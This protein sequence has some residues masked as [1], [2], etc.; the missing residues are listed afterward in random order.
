MGQNGSSVGKGSLELIQFQLLAS[1]LI[2]DLGTYFENSN[3]SKSLSNV[4][5]RTYFSLQ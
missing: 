5:S 1:V 2:N 3:V 4:K